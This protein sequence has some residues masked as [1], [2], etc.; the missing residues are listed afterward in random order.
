MVTPRTS[1]H[2]TDTGSDTLPRL[3]LTRPAW[4]ADALCREPSALAEVGCH[5]VDAER[6]KDARERAMQVCG[7]CAVMLE[8]REYALADPSLLGVFGGTD[9]AA[10]KAMRA[11]RERSSPDVIRTARDEPGSSLVHDTHRQHPPA[12]GAPAA[13]DLTASTAN[14]GSPD[15]IPPQGEGGPVDHG[16]CAPPPGDPGPWSLS[17]SSPDPLNAPDALIIPKGPI[18]HD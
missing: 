2:T 8:C 3:D 13:T 10:R 9:S 15:R 16:S 18:P 6:H 4:F 5:F 11:N 12:P 7:R 14:P 1:R 17:N